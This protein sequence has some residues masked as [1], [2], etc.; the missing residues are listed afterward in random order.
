M[1]SVDTDRSSQRWWLSDGLLGA[2]VVI[3][4][5]ATAFAAY[6]SALTGIEG[7][8]LDL[9][10]QKTLVVA[11]GS[12]LNGNAEIIQDLQAYDAYR[13]FS[14]EDPAEAAVYLERMSVTLRAGL[15]RPDGPFDDD[16]LAA[17]YADAKALLAQV[18]E[19]ETQANQIDDQNRVYERA[20]FLFAIGLAATAWASLVDAGRQLRL[21]FLIIALICLFGGIG[22]FVF[23][24]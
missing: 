7:D 12:F 11:T 17:T 21:I 10:T 8:D 13:F 1:N 4:T 15:E 23:Q 22:V 14:T 24:L 3:L 18:D 9:E 19:L 2:M 16:Y 5:A 20:G 6:Q